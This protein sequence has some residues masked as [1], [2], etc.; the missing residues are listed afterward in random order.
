MP[1]MSLTL[2]Q[3]TEA[4]AALPVEQRGELVDRIVINMARES[5][6][7]FD[8]AWGKE[9]LRRR[10][11]IRSGSVKAIPG[12][13]VHAEMKRRYPNAD[14][15]LNEMRPAIFG[16]FDFAEGSNSPG[17]DSSE[18]PGVP[19][20]WKPMLRQSNQQADEGALAGGD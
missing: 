10:D 7:A 19:V 18:F 14:G 15:P 16:R 3:L 1:A 5:N 2:D 12:H 17:T 13:L 6:A 4:A 9:A 20:G 11:Q 8:A